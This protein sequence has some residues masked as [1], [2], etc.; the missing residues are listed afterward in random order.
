[1]RI[2]RPFRTPHKQ[3]TGVRAGE[4]CSCSCSCPTTAI[5]EA[6][7]A[8]ASLACQ[9]SCLDATLTSER[10]GKPG[11]TFVL[12]TPCSHGQGWFCV[13]Q[14][15]PFVLA[16]SHRARIHS[17]VRGPSAV[18]VVSLRTRWAPKACRGSRF[19]GG[20]ERPG[21]PKRNDPATR[22]RRQAAILTRHP[23]HY[24][25]QRDDSLNRH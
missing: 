25:R 2:V 4:A 24:H 22:P 23:A 10:L 19:A 18:E 7:R 1:M 8:P 17:G 16:S 12:C 15:T 5:L 20:Q 14:K 6:P 21:A 3:A 13:A 9:A 11:A